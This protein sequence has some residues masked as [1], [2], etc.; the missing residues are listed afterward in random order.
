MLQS[1]KPLF[2]DFLTIYLLCLTISIH[3]LQWHTLAALSEC[4]HGK[5][6]VHMGIK[7]QFE[8]IE[9]NLK[10]STFTIYPDNS[11]KQAF[12]VFITIFVAYWAI[13]LPVVEFGINT[14]MSISKG[15]STYDLEFGVQP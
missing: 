3:G 10:R 1:A 4:T 6:T 12:D 11:L 7:Q 8:S 5:H 9:R 15:K 2:Y 14:T 13:I